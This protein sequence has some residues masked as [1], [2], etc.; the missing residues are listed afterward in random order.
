[1]GN[2][3]FNNRKTVKSYSKIYGKSKRIRKHRFRSF[4]IYLTLFFFIAA[5]AYISC[6]IVYSFL[7]RE[8]VRHVVVPDSYDEKPKVSEVKQQNKKEQNDVLE[9]L[10]IKAVEV[11]KNLIFNEESF[12]SF[13]KKAKAAGNNSVVVVLKDLAGSLL[14]KSDVY[15]AKLWKTVGKNA[16]DAQNIVELI[17]EEGLI[18][19]AKISAF[20]D[21]KAPLAFRDNTFVYENDED[22]MFKFKD[23]KTNR[24]KPFLNPASKAAQRYILRLVE[25]ITDFGFSYV[26]V[27]NISFPYVKDA[28]KIKGYDEIEKD[29]IIKKF[30]G[31]L[32]KINPK[33]AIEYDFSSLKDYDEDDEDDDANILFGGDVSKFGAVLQIPVIKNFEDYKKFEEFELKNKNSGIKFVLKLEFKNK[34]KA[35]VEKLDEEN[36]SYVIN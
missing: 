34:I 22:V 3:N 8:H 4:R 28:S 11:P 20:Y 23:L 17:K 2:K 27:N 33:T 19:I 25:E 5:F 36:K 1:M 7:N 16:V 35:V 9:N 18:P 30:I 24:Q 26:V 29:V 12:V 31:M 21:E 13:L 32:K 14:Y 10:N 6:V 15:E